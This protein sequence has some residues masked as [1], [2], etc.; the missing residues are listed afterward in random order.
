MKLNENQ[1]KIFW[2][3]YTAY[4]DVCSSF[5][6]KSEDRDP[7]PREYDLIHEEALATAYEVA[8]KL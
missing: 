3:T 4:F 5:T 2:G 1:T 8:S 7:T 6:R